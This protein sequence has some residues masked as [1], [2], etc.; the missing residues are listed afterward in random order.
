MGYSNVG[1]G[2]NR[3][4]S[5]GS[6]DIEIETDKTLLQRVLINLFKNSLEATQKGGNVYCGV[7]EAEGK[8]IFFVKNNSF[9]PE[10]VQMKIFQRSFST[11]GTGRGV[12]T[13]S[14]RL[15]TENYLKGKVLFSSSEAEGTVF[16]I[17][18]NR[19][20]IG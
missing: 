4:I 17:E 15:L 1:I 9:L 11:K 20:F 5:V 3:L 18:L 19:E 2:K 16:K 14:I 6:D 13:Y 8:I 7:E 10:D 12:G